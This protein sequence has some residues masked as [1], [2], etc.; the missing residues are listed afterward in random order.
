MYNASVY[1]TRDMGPGAKP[2]RT[3]S[4]RSFLFKAVVAR[5]NSETSKGGFVLELNVS[6]STNDQTEIFTYAVN[7]KTLEPAR[8]MKVGTRTLGHVL[9]LPPMPYER[10]GTSD[11]PADLLL[12]KLDLTSQ[13]LWGFFSHQVQ[14][15][16]LSHTKCPH[17]SF[18]IPELV[19]VA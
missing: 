6:Y 1:P 2:R 14:S 16:D 3:S 12:R 10:N 18:E 11:N 4:L 19:F 15:H 7:L 5:P 9:L 13:N 8:T 17:H